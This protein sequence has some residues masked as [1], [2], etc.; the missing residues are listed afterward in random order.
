MILIISYISQAGMIFIL[1]PYLF[2]S[3]RSKN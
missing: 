2:L 3:E 1:Y